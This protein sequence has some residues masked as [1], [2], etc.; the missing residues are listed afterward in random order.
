MP[1]FPKPPKC[2]GPG[3]AVGGLPKAPRD[4]PLVMVHCHDVSQNPPRQP[5]GNAP[6][7]SC[8]RALAPTPANRRTRPKHPSGNDTHGK[9]NI[10]PIVNQPNKN[11]KKTTQRARHQTRKGPPPPPPHSR[12]GNTRP[13]LP[14]SCVLIR[15]GDTLNRELDRV[16]KNG[17]MLFW[18]EYVFTGAF[19]KIREALLELSSK[20]EKGASISETENHARAY[21]RQAFDRFKM[22]MEKA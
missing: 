17:K 4:M 18:Q 2:Q 11:K 16:L 15:Q 12:N 13:H 9:E 5:T 1:N 14:P 3:L 21:A 10:K 6:T 20:E 7:V 8:Q 19:R 22:C